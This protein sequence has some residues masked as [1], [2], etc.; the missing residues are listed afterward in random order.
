VTA[1]AQRLARA[2]RTSQVQVAVAQS[3]V[4]ADLNVFVHLERQRRSLAE[5]LDV[6]GRDLDPASGQVGVFV[7]GRA[8]LHHTGQLNARLRAKSVHGI[9]ITHD[10]LHDTAGIADVDERDASVIASTS[11]PARE[12]HC[13]SGVGRS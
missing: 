8:G 5:H 10:R 6:L 12:R 3:D 7:S 1:N 11:H 13:C 2:T 9:G 4:F